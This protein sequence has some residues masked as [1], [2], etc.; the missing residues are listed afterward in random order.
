MSVES[1]RTPADL[2]PDFCSGRAVLSVMVL[3]ELVAV[4]SVFITQPVGPLFWERFILLSLYMQ[5]IA[6][7]SAAVLCQARSWLQRMQPWFVLFASY[8]LLLGLAALLAELAWLVLRV[9]G[10]DG[11]LR[12]G[13]HD[14]FVIATLG[15]V[16]IVSLLA[17]RYFWVQAQWRQ[18]IVA[19]ADARYQ[20]L[21]ARIR[22]HF[23]FNTLNSL[24]ALID[25]DPRS[26]ENMVTDLADLFRV[27]LERRQRMA[28]L[29]EEI[30]LTRAYLNIEQ[31]RLGER[32]RVE[33]DIEAGAKAVPVPLLSL[34]PLAEN[35]VHHG[36][37]QI[38][39]GGTVRIAA[40]LADVR[41]HPGLELVVENPVPETEPGPR[42]TRLALANLTER[43]RLVYGE[44]ARLDAGRVDAGAGETAQVFRACIRV[45]VLRTTEVE[46]NA[47]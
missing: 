21:Q 34:Q 42:G 46:S 15:T 44:L 23:L 19:E 8:C 17:L 14:Q 2:L 10:W 6:V 36:I 40:R 1:P 45:P 28:T 26:A 7:C 29:A 39:G 25:K 31:V 11:L 13:S 22:P 30:D 4:L 20:A 43:L 33:W 3:A 38:D 9:L 24:A 37:G 5:W 12:V 27:A 41:G 32:L 35:A 16:G 18:Q 47:A